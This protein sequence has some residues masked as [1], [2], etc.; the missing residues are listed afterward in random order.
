MIV[1]NFE[2][3]GGYGDKH[4]LLLQNQNNYKAFLGKIKT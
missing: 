2:G 1:S 4:T 3:L